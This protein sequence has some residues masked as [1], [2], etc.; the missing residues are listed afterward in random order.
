MNGG[1]GF[2]FIDLTI[3]LINFGALVAMPIPSLTIC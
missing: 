1:N 2:T 3:V